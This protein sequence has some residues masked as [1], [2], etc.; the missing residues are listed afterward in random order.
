[1]NLKKLKKLL[2]INNYTGLNQKQNGFDDYL[3]KLFKNEIYH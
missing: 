3:T 1:M 2:S